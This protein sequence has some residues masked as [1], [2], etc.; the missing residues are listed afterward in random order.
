MSAKDYVSR[1]RAKKFSKR[2]LVIG[3]VLV[4]GAVIYSVMEN[5]ANKKEEEAEAQANQK[6]IASEVFNGV[7]E[8]SVPQS[9]VVTR[10]LTDYIENQKAVNQQLAD[11]INDLESQ[12]QEYR[13]AIIE[14]ESNTFAIND[15]LEILNT[16]KAQL[17]ANESNT[18]LVKPK[19]QFQIIE[20]DINSSDNNDGDD[21]T[22]S[23]AAKQGASNNQ[24]NTPVDENSPEA[25][26]AKAPKVST[27]IP[28]NTFAKGVLV[29]AL[30]A[31][32]GGNAST[33]PTPMLIRLTNLAQLPNKFRSNLRSCMV[34]A[35]GW[36]DLST[37]RVKARLTNLSCVLKDGR[38]LDIPVDGYISGEDARAGIRGLLVQH[39][40]SLVAKA[41]L[42][43]FIQGIGQIGTAMGQTQ[44]ITP[45]GGV[46]TTVSPQQALVAGAGQGVS[47]AGSTLSQY[48]L[49]QLQQ[50]SP[51][52]EVSAGRHVTVIFTKGIELNLPINEQYSPE[53]TQLPIHE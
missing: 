50:I 7:G 10:N 4:A 22:F 48:Y 31:N 30:S 49:Q 15:K 26:A 6:I 19:P 18:A 3:G 24:S 8:V 51:S 38:A 43:G 37:E 29:S 44:T 36:G 34:G 5:N 28:S 14:A 13:Q 46:T 39:S 42:A 41:A 35:S 23:N 1:F 33:D 45:L 32:T 17:L 2:F 16:Q 47:Q 20:D 11:R 53:K 25:K 9:E 21:A 27:Y 12:N 52:I 40:G